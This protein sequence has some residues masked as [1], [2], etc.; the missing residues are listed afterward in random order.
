[1]MNI[2]EIFGPVL[3]GEGITS[4]VPAFFIRMSTCNLMCGGHNGSLV[5]EGKATW[6]CDSE[7][8]WKKGTP[9]TPQQ[10][11][12]KIDAEGELERVFSG[13]THIILTGGEPALPI[14]Q[15]AIV[16]LVNY[17]KE[18]YPFATPFYEMETNGTRYTDGFYDEFIHQINCSPKL[19][20]CG[21]P[22]ST[23]IIPKALEEI[24]KHQN[25]WFKLVVSEESDWDE[26]ERDFL[27]Y[28]DKDKIILMPAGSTSEE[29]RPSFQT[30]WEL[31]CKHNL[32]ACGRYQVWAWEQTT[33]I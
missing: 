2:S 12:D 5:K 1:M 9:W 7:T 15:K 16:E 26:I 22:Q 17:I 32:R 8:V 14:N 28:I 33:G 30:V 27:P 21:M 4:G 18:K 6:W 19:G 31:A 11:I 24:N 3:Q 13:R 10:I 29:L 25:S 23:R 20:N